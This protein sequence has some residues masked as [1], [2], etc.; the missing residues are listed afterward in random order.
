MLKRAFLF[1]FAGWLL[2]N[3]CGCFALVAG[4]V[5][6]AGT[7]MWL[8]GKLTQEMN[9][10]F[11]KTLQAAR[12]AMKSLKLQ[13]TKETV[14]DSTAQIIGKY[15]DGKT[16]WIDVHRVTASSSKVEVRVG[17]MEGDKVAADKI[18]K[19]IGRYL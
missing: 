17:A 2:V 4:A 12:D 5:G 11:E 8:A 14:E 18:I 10:S 19:R 6:G 15:S 16:I 7:G 3:S 1:V 9:A 13:V